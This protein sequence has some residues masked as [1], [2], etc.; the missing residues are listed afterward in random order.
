MYVLMLIIPDVIAVFV[1]RH[2]RGDQRVGP[3]VLVDIRR[4]HLLREFRFFVIFVL[5][6]DTNRRRAR[7]RRFALNKTQFFSEHLH[8]IKA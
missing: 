3:G 5:R 2:H 1:G 4:V 6:V 7:F 8:L